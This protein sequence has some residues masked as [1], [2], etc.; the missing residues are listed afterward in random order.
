M[1]ILSKVERGSFI[2]EISIENVNFREECNI[3]NL[4]HFKILLYPDGSYITTELIDAF[5]SF[6]LVMAVGY[7]GRGSLVQQSPC[8]KKVVISMICFSILVV[9]SLFLD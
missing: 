6:Y 7:L 5:F 9:K 3:S 4:V 2:F 8:R 1:Q